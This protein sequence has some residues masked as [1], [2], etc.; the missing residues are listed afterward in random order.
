MESDGSRSAVNNDISEVMLLWATIAALLAT[1]T[2]LAL[3]DV[4]LSLVGIGVAATC[5]TLYVA[6]RM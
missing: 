4:A 2:A 5:A 3:G 6:W 1:F